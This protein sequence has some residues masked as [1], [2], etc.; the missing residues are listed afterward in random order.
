M[1]IQIGDVNAATP[2]ITA[3]RK[4]F[5]LSSPANRFLFTKHQISVVKPKIEA[6]GQSKNN[7]A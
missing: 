4:C 2:I 5:L 1:I 7:A 3:S 6:V